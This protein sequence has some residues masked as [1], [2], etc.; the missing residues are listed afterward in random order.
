MLR[1]EEWTS[2]PVARTRIRSR[3]VS[4]AHLGCLRRASHRHQRF[5]SISVPTCRAVV[6]AE[7]EED[8]RNRHQGLATTSMLFLP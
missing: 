7:S 3:H 6:L 2:G 1:V 8:A 5:F 4:A